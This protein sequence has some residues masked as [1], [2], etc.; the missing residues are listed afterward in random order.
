MRGA[1][2]HGGDVAFKCCLYCL[3]SLNFEF[4]VD[5]YQFIP[6]SAL[7]DVLYIKLHFAVDCLFVQTVTLL[8]KW[9]CTV[10]QCAPCSIQYMRLAQGVMIGVE[11]KV[12]I[13]CGIVSLTV[14]FHQKQAPSTRR[15]TFDPS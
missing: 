7:H 8:L 13:I 12:I 2:I 11:E 14:A 10:W 1:I 15:T 3:V 5:H 6:L 4:G 9:V